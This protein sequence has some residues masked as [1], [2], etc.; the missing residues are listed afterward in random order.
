MRHP[1][2][3][4]IVA[5]ASTFGGLWFDDRHEA[6]AGVLVV[7]GLLAAC[8]VLALEFRLRTRGEDP[9]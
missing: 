9:S 4:L 1:G 8:S 3:L 2:A 7:I 5:V 6:L